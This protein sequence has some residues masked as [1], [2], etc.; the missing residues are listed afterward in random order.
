MTLV[1]RRTLAQFVET[2]KPRETRIPLQAT[3]ETTFRCNLACVHCY[4][5]KAV[6]DANERATELEL[7]RLQKLIDEAVARGTLELLLTGGEILVRPDFEALYSHA[8]RSGLMVVLFTNGT[9]ITE[10]VAAFL[11][12]HK[13]LRVEITLYGM[14]EETYERV[15]QVKGSYAKCL[16]GI[17]LLLKNGVP[18]KL[19]TIVL[20][21][22]QHELPAMQAFAASKGLDFKFDGFLNP[23]VDC[24]ANRNAELQVSP[25]QLLKL[26]LADPA[27]LLEFKQ[28]C[29][30]HVPKPQHVAAQA[31]REK[32]YTC[33][34]G[35]TSFT[36]DPSGHMQLCQ[37]SRKNSFELKAQAFKEGWDVFFPKLRDRTWKTNSVC[38]TCNLMSL[39]SSCPGSA[40][41]ETGSVEG[42]VATFCRTTHLRAFEIL[43]ENSG[44]VRD[45]SCCLGGAHNDPPIN[46]G[47]CGCAESGSASSNKPSRQAESGR[48]HKNSDLMP[49]KTK[50]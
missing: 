24:G 43:G 11:G 12:A 7:S 17:E 8:L 33:G 30:T 3:V 32:L 1:P 38:R 48:S 36:V 47:G 50:G 6:D 37:L 18:L 20:T 9:M 29:D 41:M 40:E 31:P 45:G 15:T 4:V 49:N 22:N 23:R 35:V 42:I 19:K 39:C 14:T 5:N 21:W 34:A 46:A 10:K 13:P 16:R 2:F 28:F 27:R 26:D 25:E 44:H